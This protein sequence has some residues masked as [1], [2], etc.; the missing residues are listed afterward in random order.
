MVFLLIS[1]VL[2]HFCSYQYEYMHNAETTAIPF[3]R[4]SARMVFKCKKGQGNCRI[5]LYLSRSALTFCQSKRKPASLTLSAHN[6]P[7]EKWIAC[8]HY[9]ATCKPSRRTFWLKECTSHKTFQR[10]SLHLAARIIARCC[11]VILHY[12][13]ITFHKCFE[14]GFIMSTSQMEDLSGMGQHV[15]IGV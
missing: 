13:L 5:F 6:F 4:Q 2:L 3:L 7:Q 1:E 11:R 8:I 12:L 9:G 10:P 15:A 14:T